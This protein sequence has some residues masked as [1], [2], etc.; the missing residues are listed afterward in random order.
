[1]QAQFP[2]ERK[3]KQVTPLNYFFKT[4]SYIE[5]MLGAAV[6]YMF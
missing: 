3:L 4:K 5:T 2:P 1:M 6:K